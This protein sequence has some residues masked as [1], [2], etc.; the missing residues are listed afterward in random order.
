MTLVASAVSTSRSHALVPS[1]HMP[2]APRFSN[3]LVLLNA[4][5][6][7]CAANP[8]SQLNDASLASALTLMSVHDRPGEMIGCQ[9]AT[10]LPCLDATLSH[11]RITHAKGSYPLVARHTLA[12]LSFFPVWL[13]C[14][15]SWCSLNSFSLNTSFIPAI[16]STSMPPCRNSH[17]CHQMAAE[18]S[19]FPY[20]TGLKEDTLAFMPRGSQITINYGLDLIQQAAAATAA[21]AAAA[22][23]SSDNPMLTAPITTSFIVKPFNMDE[24]P[25]AEYGESSVDYFNRLYHHLLC[26]ADYHKQFKLTQL[27]A[28]D[29]IVA[30]QLQVW[31]A[32]RAKIAMTACFGTV[33]NF[34][35][36]LEELLSFDYPT[37]ARFIQAD[38]HVDTRSAEWGH[39][40][41]PATDPNCLAKQALANHDGRYQYMLVAQ[42]EALICQHENAM[43]SK[44]LDEMRVR[45]DDMLFDIGGFLAVMEETRPA[46]VLAAQEE[47]S[48][49]STSTP[50]TS[51]IASHLNFMSDNLRPA[52]PAA[53]ALAPPPT[54]PSSSNISPLAQ[55]YTSGQGSQSYSGRGSG[56]HGRG[57]SSDHYH[58]PYSHSQ[59]QNH[60]KQPHKPAE[61]SAPYNPTNLTA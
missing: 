41:L 52:L 55:K 13:P 51:A 15:N 54:T 8:A 46:L 35:A 43:K 6:L 22:P 34:P 61:A 9:L 39:V 29:I 10:W 28:S 47:S 21:A 42:S 18:S 4:L 45:A 48:K 37:T 30:K 11:R 38:S 20:L 56:Y 5:P 1:S 49:L 31:C 23:T 17:F 32:R 3:L 57:R 24:H 14:F 16:F 26:S 12:S 40:A 7:T 60:A 44:A 50:L 33:S 58:H 36:N 53:P 59:R 25:T 2:Q 27:G 19:T